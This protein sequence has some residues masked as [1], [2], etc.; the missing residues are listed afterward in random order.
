LLLTAKT[1][2]TLDESPKVTY[3]FINFL[4]IGGAL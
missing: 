2:I 3:H 4:L 1:T